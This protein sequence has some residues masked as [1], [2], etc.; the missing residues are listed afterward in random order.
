VLSYTYAP[1]GKT[2]L[3]TTSTEINLRLYMASAI[4]PAGELRYMLRNQPFDSGAVMEFADY[5]LEGFKR[6]LLIV[7]DG[8]S[9]HH[10]K[11]F[12]EYLDRKS[13]GELHL[14]MQPHYSPELNADEQ[15]WN[16]QTTQTQKHVQPDVEN[17]QRKSQWCHGNPQT[18][19]PHH[20]KL[21][22]P[23][24]TWLL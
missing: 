3:I 5:L 10:S 1:K 17:T 6:K 7:W 22:S 12:R 24:R 21:F 14:V 19:T 20:P 15:V 2:P 18:T 9:I 13:N 8:A 11:A 16:S 23:P 4:T